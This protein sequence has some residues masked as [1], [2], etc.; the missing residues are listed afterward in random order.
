M[1][2]VDKKILSYLC[3]GEGVFINMYKLSKNLNCHRNTVRS[4][5][6][7]LL[8]HK[9]IRPPTCLYNL[10]FE[11]LPL[12]SI[13]YV[14][15]PLDKIDKI[16]QDPNVV[17]V[18]KVHEGEYNI[19]TFSFWKNVLAHKVWEEKNFYEDALVGDSEA[20][21]IPT[22][23][24]FKMNFNG[25]LPRLI[26]KNA[27]V[28]GGQVLDNLSFRI[29]CYL[30]KGNFLWINEQAIAKKVGVH[31]RTVKRRISTYFNKNIIS[32]PKCYFYSYFTP[33][34]RLMVLSLFESRNPK[35]LR[36]YFKKDPH[37]MMLTK[38]NRMEY[39]HLILSSH[40]SISTYTNWSDGF[41]RAFKHVGG[42]DV[43]F[44]PSEN[45]L[46]TDFNPIIKKLL[47]SK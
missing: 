36:T 20:M 35:L 13:D 15:Y 30:L 8:E 19:L 14:N 24:I 1:D 31:R 45:I 34:D 33:P 28:F 44:I 25:I 47:Y 3:L 42:Q 2:S 6:N 40:N 22:A 46:K 23:F 21:Y 43:I 9:I 11:K 4:R 29:L 5:V 39:T 41:R 38:V 27:R 26:E 16:V 10:L 12:M 17:G 18:Y 32:S 7:S 37:V